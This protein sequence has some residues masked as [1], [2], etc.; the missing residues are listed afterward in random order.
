[1]PKR[2]G[3]YLIEKLAD[4]TDLPILKTFWISLSFRNRLIFANIK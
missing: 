2:F 1:L 3:A 4:F